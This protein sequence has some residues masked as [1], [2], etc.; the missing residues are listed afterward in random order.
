MDDSHTFIAD[1]LDQLPEIPDDSIVSRTILNDDHLKTILF[2]FAPG[3]ELSEHT[4]AMSATI[5][6]L[7]GEATLTLGDQVYDAQPGSWAHMP[8]R[9]PHSLMAK[10]EPV[11]MLLKMYK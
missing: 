6:I 9:L 11:V 4:S 8:P 2:G 1:L 5:H 7:A 10:A 3:Q